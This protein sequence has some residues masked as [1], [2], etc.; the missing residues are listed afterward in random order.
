M[1]RGTLVW[2]TAAVRSRSSYTFERIRS[3]EDAMIPPNHS[4]VRSLGPLLILALTATGC[5]GVPLLPVSHPAI[6]ERIDSLELSP[7]AENASTDRQQVPLEGRVTLVNFWGT[8]CPPCRRELPGLARLAAH[9]AK[10]PRFQLVA[11]S[12]G[13]DRRDDPEMLSRETAEFL[14]GERLSLSPWADFDGRVR[15]Q[16]VRQFGLEAFPTTYL[17]GADA[18]VRKVWVGYRSS[19]ESAIAAAVVELL[20]ESP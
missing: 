5:G 10:E 2:E 9:L 18:T 6:G 20:R 7:L 17:V 11:I 16:F 14:A 13:P 12:C 1:F 15:G 19:D 8:W 3:E 4:T